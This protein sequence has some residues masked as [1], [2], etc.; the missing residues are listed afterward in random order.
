MGNSS[1]KVC[2]AT[3]F[4]GCLNCFGPALN[5]CL[6]CSSSLVLQA[7]QCVSNCSVGYYQSNNSCLPCPSQCASCIN[8]IYC[9]SCSSGFF[10]NFI[11]CN[12]MCQ[13]AY[14]PLIVSSNSTNSTNSTNSSQIQCAACPTGCQ[15]CKNS[16]F[17]QECTSDYFLF[18]FTC[19]KNNPMSFYFDFSFGKFKPCQ[20]NCLQCN[21]LVCFKCSAGY[22]LNQGVCVLNCGPDKFPFMRSFYNDTTL[23][24]FCEWKSPQC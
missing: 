15:R 11:F 13:S 5:Q 4:S 8:A 7:G 21:E 1:A 18:N 24:G 2:N 16:N 17:C 19:A 10:L 12:R 3:C 23:Y 20:S 6:S 9:T 22:F 14:Y